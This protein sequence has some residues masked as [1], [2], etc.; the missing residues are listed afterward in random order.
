M[1]IESAQDLLEQHQAA[2]ARLYQAA[3]AAQWGLSLSQFAEALRQSCQRRQ[4]ES[5]SLPLEKLLDSLHVGDLAL[6]AACRIGL[7]PAWN[8]LVTTYRPVMYAAA[9]AIA[10]DDVRGRELADSLYAD[11]YGLEIRAGRRR[12]LLQYFDGR[13]S[14]STWLH[15]VIARRFVD[16]YRQER[17]TASIGDCP[18]ATLSQAAGTADP[19]DPDRTRYL[20]LLRTALDIALRSLKP[21]DRLR[22]GCYYMEN[23]TLKQVGELLGEHESSVSRR[24][25]RTRKALRRQVERTLRREQRLS[26]EQIA[27]CYDYATQEWP[28]DLTGA[29][30]QSDRS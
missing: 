16:N 19:P 17:R 12:S 3:R 7:E 4:S 21:R 1:P 9:R 24:L 30:S 26:D 29:F 13:S 22:L 8:A 6:A 10:R 23:L 25:T 2:I 27:L 20:E 18:P 11:L 15:A 5:A 14:L 28:F